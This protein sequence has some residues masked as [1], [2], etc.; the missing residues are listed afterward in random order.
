MSIEQDLNW[1]FSTGRHD[2]KTMAVPAAFAPAL[3]GYGM[4]VTPGVQA[5]RASP[6]ARL[7]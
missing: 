3:A 2:C 6:S 1:L 4:D 7:C 5:V